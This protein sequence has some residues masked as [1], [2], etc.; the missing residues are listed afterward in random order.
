MDEANLLPLRDTLL[1]AL[2]GYQTG[3]KTIVVQLCLAIA[4]LA[5]QLPAWD[6]A[7]HNMIDSFGRNPATV[8][9]LLQFLTLLPE[10][11]NSNTR[12]PV[13]VR[14]SIMLH[15]H[16]AYRLQDDE[17]RERSA[18]LLTANAEKVLDLLSMYIQA[19]GGSHAGLATVKPL[20]LVKVSPTPCKLK[21]LTACGAG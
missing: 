10:E 20:I 3:P 19:S 5:L 15:M 14:P 8:P 2:E 17:Y 13:T 7:V 21:F 11:L 12:I 4:G 9:T 1:T 16:I 6:N 18:N